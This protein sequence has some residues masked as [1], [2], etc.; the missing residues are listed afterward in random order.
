MNIA[1][2]V[3]LFLNWACSSLQLL[4][5]T[6]CLHML[7]HVLA[8]K[9]AWG[10]TNSVAICCL[11]CSSYDWFF[12]PIS[13]ALLPT[14]SANCPNGSHFAQMGSHFAHIT[15]PNPY[16]L[17]SC[18]KPFSGIWTYTKHP[19]A[20]PKTSLLLAW[21]WKWAKQTTV[22]AILTP[23]G[24]SVWKVGKSILEVGRKKKIYM[25][26]LSLV[27]VA[28][29]SHGLQMLIQHRIVGLQA[30]QLSQLSYIL[31]VALS[32]QSNCKSLYV[33]RHMHGISP[34]VSGT[35]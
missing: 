30:L 4:P 32:W 11:G 2:E 7:L 34:T 9:L 14:F 13:R 25:L 22:W 31:K 23:T 28:Y 35:H 27:H 17:L 21:T 16:S 1:G 12:F 29:N 15:T 18:H 33:H 19:Q 6:M 24:Q 10:E 3:T 5:P 8:G 20:H 26:L